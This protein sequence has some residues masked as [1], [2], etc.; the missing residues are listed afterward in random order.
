MTPSARLHLKVDWDQR[1]QGDNGRRSSLTT[2]DGTDCPI[3]E[4]P[5]T[6]DSP[7]PFD[8][9]WFS[10][11]F[12]GA[13]VKYELLVAIQT[14]DIVSVS[15]PFPCGKWHDLTVFRRKAKQML[16]P[17][18]TVEADRG[19]RGD[20]KCRTPE[21]YV[22]QSERRAKERARARHEVI[23][24]RLKNF[25]VLDQKFRHPLTQHK[26][27]FALAVTMVQLTTMHHGP[28]FHVKY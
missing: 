9:K 23:N 2:V 12:G 16:E 27:Y 4:P 17:W 19:Y 20:P 21:Q 8:R 26:F 7:L 22:T 5:K 6:D 3:N 14:G 24:G 1:F 18:E 15:G 10:H 28:P 11:K 25:R 13:G